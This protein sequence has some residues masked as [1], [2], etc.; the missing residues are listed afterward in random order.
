MLSINIKDFFEANKNIV[1][2]TIIFVIIVIV[3]IIIGSRIYHRTVFNASEYYGEV[4]NENLIEE[5]QRWDIETGVIYQQE[6]EIDRNGLSNILLYLDNLNLNESQ[7]ITVQLISEENNQIIDEWEKHNE[8]LI[9]GGYTEFPLSEPLIGEN[10]HKFTIS[11]FINSDKYTGTNFSDYEVVNIDGHL[12]YSLQATHYK[13]I[14]KYYMIGIVT[15]ILCVS[16]VIGF[17]I[18][19]KKISWQNM[20]IPV[21]LVCGIAYMVVF[22]PFTAPDEYSHFV[23]SYQL[24][25]RMIGKDLPDPE[26]QIAQDVFLGD[27]YFTRY[28]TL[29][30]YKYVW[31]ALHESVG[32]DNSSEYVNNL[33]DYVGATGH[34][35][36]AIGISIAKLLNLP[37]IYMVY[38]GRFFNL[39]IWSVLCYWIIRITPVGKMIFFVISCL[40]MT[41]ELAASYSRDIYILELAYIFIAYILYLTLEKEKIKIINII[42][43]SLLLILLLPCKYIYVIIGFLVL[44]LP[45]KKIKNKKLYVGLI[46]TTIIFLCVEFAICM[47]IEQA[48]QANPLNEVTTE[49]VVG[50]NTEFYNREDIFSN[51]IK[52]V[53]VFIDTLWENLGFYLTTMVGS[54]LGSLEILLPDFFVFCFYLLLILACMQKNTNSVYI[55][56][57][58]RKILIGVFGIAFLSTLGAML[59][60]W[61][62]SSSGIIEGIQGRY[63]LPVIPL[64]CLAIQ[65]KNL[66]LNMNL[67]KIIIIG[68][69]VLHYFASLSCF[70]KIVLS[71]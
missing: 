53:N 28:S 42:F 44:I 26:D 25:E 20:I 35:V 71:H 22:P 37:Y 51:P 18:F 34:F 60:G 66:V 41:L 64:L 48:K 55:D 7:Y 43:L 56:A 24:S 69:V 30:S 12:Q 50:E 1:Y 45:L 61:T 65:R 58:R 4:Y 39:L 21:I 36:P 46:V 8:E 70:E 6:I 33:F 27:G 29:N 14:D 49:A 40:P 52:I 54:Q 17:L 57:C 11:M 15:F 19:G 62:S 23:A 5:A 38:L 59:I 3:F 68:E 63:F 16:A 9:V 67:T 13:F 31:D 32:S 47:S 2:K 10:G